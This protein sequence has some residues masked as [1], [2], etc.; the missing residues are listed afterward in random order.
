MGRFARE[1][2]IFFFVLLPVSLALFLLVDFYL[3]N[4]G[5]YNKINIAFDFDQAWFVEILSYPPDEWI[6]KTASDVN[7]LILKHLLLYLYRWPSELLQFFG[8]SPE[9]AVII[10]SVLFHMGTMT[11]GFYIFSDVFQSFAKAFLLCIFM[12]F[13]ATYLVN[14]IVVDSYVLAGFWITCAFAIYQSDLKATM[15]L[16]VD[17]L[18]IIVYVMAVGTTTYLLLLV[19]VLEASL[20]LAKR[21]DFSVSHI[22]RYLLSGIVRF[23]L[24]F[25]LLFSICYYQSL[26]EIVSDPVNVVQKTLWAVV[27]G[28]EKEG[29]TS[30]LTTFLFYTFFAP[31][32]TVVDIGNN[33]L[34]AD[35]RPGENVFVTYSVIAVLAAAL[36]L[37]VKKPDPMLL[38]SFIWLGITIGFHL[39]YQDRGSIFLYT[40]HTMLPLMVIVACFFSN[41]SPVKY[42]IIAGLLTMVLMLNNVLEIYWAINATRGAW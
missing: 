38:V 2:K 27:R 25:F 4:E 14:G 40:G 11:V 15:R 3:L 31:S 5:F 36:V 20:V 23:S 17:W 21:H 16:E 39:Q 42:L 24:L 1:E 8:F 7:P 30:I 32:H 37:L 22:T 26:S 9:E 29:V 19:I 18:K 6:Y 33:A 12:L 35:F 28:G 41:L 34:M 10:V 13:S